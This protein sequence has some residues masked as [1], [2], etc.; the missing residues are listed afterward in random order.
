MDRKEGRMKEAVEKREEKERGEPER[1]ARG[2]KV[3]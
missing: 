2:K 1:R 3:R